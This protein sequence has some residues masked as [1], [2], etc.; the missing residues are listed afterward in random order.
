M[1]RYDNV[2]VKRQ[3][4]RQVLSMVFKAI[5]QGV[6]WIGFLLRQPVR[7]FASF[8]LLISLVGVAFSLLLFDD[9]GFAWN[10]GKLSVSMVL[11]PFLYDFVLGFI[12]GDD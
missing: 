10:M 3:T 2:Q 4:H 7:M 12:A 8:F 9:P 1:S 6:A 5:R 11:L